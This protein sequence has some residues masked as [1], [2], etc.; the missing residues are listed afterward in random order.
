MAS[1]H[2][3][4]APEE[5]FNIAGFSVTNSTFT[6]VIVTTLIFIIAKYIGDNVSEKPTSNF[7]VN[8]GELVVSMWNSLCETIG[9]KHAREF[10]PLVTSIFVFVIMSNWIGLLPG[11]GTIGVNQS[12]DTE[13]TQHAGLVQSAY[14]A[15][16]G[17]ENQNVVE[18]GH[19]EVVTLDGETHTEELNQAEPSHEVSFIPVFRAPTAD[20]N[21]TFALAVIAM[22]YVQFTGFQH[23][24]S[25]Y[26]QKF[27]NF[28]NPINAYVGILE[29]ISEFSKIISFSFRLFGNVF[30]GEVLLA[31]IAFLVPVIA[32]LPFIGLEIFVGFIQAFV[33]AILTLV[34]LSQAVIAHDH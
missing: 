23:L 16:T 30:A 1:L 25:H 29:L 27:F 28:S 10:F 18:V 5:I 32:S 9:G 17:I 20:L 8:L 7:M 22:I 19:E 3:S 34:F 24:G 14:A 6:T 21:T 2:V 12:H 33:F 13:S 31:V 4:I 15:E 11:V 26:S